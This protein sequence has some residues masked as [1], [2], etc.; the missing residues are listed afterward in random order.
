[1]LLKVKEING[2]SR[3]LV[4]GKNI[5]EEDRPRM[6]ISTYSLVELSTL[7]ATR[8][9]RFQGTVIGHLRSRESR[10]GSSSL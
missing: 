10:T 6:H 3:R 7:G 5:D 9:F 1:M 8:G 2:T 4:K